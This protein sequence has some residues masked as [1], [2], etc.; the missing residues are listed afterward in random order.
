MPPF[1]SGRQVEIRHGD[2]RAVVV[3]VG[4]TLRQYEVGGFPV[5]DGFDA[6]E[7]C[8][9]ARGNPLVPWPNRLRDGRYEFD[10]RVEQTAITEPAR[11]NAI[12][13]LGRWRNWQLI[14]AAPDRVRAELV[15]HPEPGYPF[16]LGCAVEYR[17][18][19]AGLS[20]TM[21]GRN[22]GG[23]E[24][25]Y[26]AGHHPY[27]RASGASTIDSTAL[28]SPARTVLPLDEGGIPTGERRPVAGELDFTASRTLGGVRLDHAF[29]GLERDPGGLARVVLSGAERTVTVWLDP[30][31][32]HLML[33][34]GDSLAPAERR[35]GL[36][37]EPMT[38]PPNALQSGEGLVVLSPGQAHRASWG[39]SVTG[40]R[41]TP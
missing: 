9:G 40:F 34:T 23:S 32:S 13:G 24:L 10:G 37:V 26:A 6:G 28:K 31:F 16:T 15:I 12:H 19:D 4:G 36:A 20:V 11:G 2:Q 35:R 39:V 1:P 30:G 5:L 14:Q 18:G 38:A 29:T 22:L 7:I 21:E 8:S 25:P 27:V 3:E 41:S 17:L 33:F